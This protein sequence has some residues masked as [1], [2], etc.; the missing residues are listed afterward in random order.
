MRYRR[1]C[2]V[3]VTATSERTSRGLRRVDRSIDRLCTKARPSRWNK[4]Y[5]L[6]C[7]RQ[8][9]LRLEET[10][11]DEDR[12]VTLPSAC[13]G[14]VTLAQPCGLPRAFSR[15]SLALPCVSPTAPWK[16]GVRPRLAI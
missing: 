1:L 2:A 8:R 3:T 5:P 11:R 10:R 14:T 12:I 4:Q 13:C 16:L 9:T 6:G 15:L 7:A